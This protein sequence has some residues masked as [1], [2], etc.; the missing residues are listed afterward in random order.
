MSM[1]GVAQ[2]HRNYVVKKRLMESMAKR[3]IRADVNGVR[4]RNATDEIDGYREGS[5]K[6]ILPSKCVYMQ[7]SQIL[8]YSIIVLIHIL[9]T[10][11]YCHP[12]TVLWCTVV[13]P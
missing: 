5:I 11:Q 9:P 2:I 10:E 6:S 3:I 13:K 1:Y 4:L 12:M 7:S 8:P